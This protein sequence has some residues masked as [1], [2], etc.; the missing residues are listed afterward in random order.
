MNDDDLYGSGDTTNEESVESEGSD[1]DEDEVE[2]DDY[3]DGD[4]K[5]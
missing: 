1:K 2:E 3:G 5:Y 4:E